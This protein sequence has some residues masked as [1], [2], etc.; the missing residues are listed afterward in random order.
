M[1]NTYKLEI[2]GRDFEVSIGKFAKQASGSAMV[3]YGD[4]QILATSV[5]SKKEED[6]GFFPLIVNYEEKLYATGKVPG[7][8]GR[9]EGRPSDNATL[10]ARLID[11]PIRP[12][13]PDGYKRE[14]QVVTTV[15]SLDKDNEPEVTAINAASIALSLSG[16]IPFE[17]PIGAVHIGRVDGEF[18]VNPTVEQR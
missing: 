3:S 13:F 17:G 15:M 4:T 5:L 11:R 8:F 10:A 16:N 18:V 14:I 6:R 9:R 2:G 7:S 1:E 12:L